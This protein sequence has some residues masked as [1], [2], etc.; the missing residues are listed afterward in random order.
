MV[1]LVED[2]AVV[3]VLVHEI[4]ERDGYRVIAA[5][6]PA[7]A[8]EA[9]RAEGAIDLLLTDVVMPGMSGTELAV[10]LAE[11]RTGLKVLYMSGYSDEQAM[12]RGLLRPGTAFI[13]K[14]FR[15]EE[16]TEKIRSLLDAA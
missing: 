16:L 12:E 3:R 9:S 6:T 1:L 8:L 15:A 4:L 10:K 13:Q 5:S 7:E 14:P 2:E 11:S